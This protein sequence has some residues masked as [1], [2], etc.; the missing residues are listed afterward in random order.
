[1]IVIYAL[2]LGMIL[3]A[4]VSYRMFDLALT[5]SARRAVEELRAALDGLEAAHA[6]KLATLEHETELASRFPFPASD[7]GRDALERGPGGPA[8]EVA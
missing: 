3:G 5:A 6:I 1:M 8:S 7:S 4:F 2:I